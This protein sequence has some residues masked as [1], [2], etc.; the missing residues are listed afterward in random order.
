MR[1]LHD[2]RKLFP[3]GGGCATRQKLLRNFL[4][5]GSARRKLPPMGKSLS[6]GPIVMEGAHRTDLTSKMF[7]QRM[8]ATDTKTPA[9]W[10][11]FE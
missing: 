10:P 9:Q 1:A 3:I 6:S 5:S 11:A 8:H 7:K 4:D 2:G